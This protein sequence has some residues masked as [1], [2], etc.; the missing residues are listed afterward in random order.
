MMFRV[1]DLPSE[2]DLSKA[3]ATFNDGALEVVMLKASP[4]KSI[5]VET[6]SDSSPEGDISVHETS[7][8]EAAR[9]PTVVTGANEPIVKA[10]AASSRR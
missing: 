10:Q 2:V 9:D 7:G 6:K 1:I 5:R 3:K 4:A 8:I